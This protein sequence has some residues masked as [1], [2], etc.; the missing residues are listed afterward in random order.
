MG[1]ARIIR[2]IKKNEEYM[3][4]EV[5][6]VEIKDETIQEKIIHKLIGDEKESKKIGIEAI[7]GTIALLSLLLSLLSLVS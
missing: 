1:K 6:E 7:I 4:I 2:E 5:E 3:K